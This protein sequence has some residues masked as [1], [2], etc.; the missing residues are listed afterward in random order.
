MHE[1][2]R[3]HEMDTTC[4]F[5]ANQDLYGIGVRAG[6]Y[7]QWTATLLAGLTLPDEA[8]SM[9]SNTLCFQIASLIAVI[10]LTIKGLI[11]Q[12]EVV[13]VL[14]LCFGG[15]LAAN[16]TTNSFQVSVLRS[17]IITQ[18]LGAFVAYSCWFWWEGV[19]IL[20]RPSCKYYTLIFVKVSIDRLRIFGISISTFGCFVFFIMELLI[21]VRMSST[22]R[23]I[24]ILEALKYLRGT[25]GSHGQV[26]ARW[27][28]WT[29]TTLAGL[30]MIYTVIMIEVTIYW[31][32][33]TEANDI[34]SV[35]Q[36]IPLIIGST[37]LFKIY[38]LLALRK[39]CVEDI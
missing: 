8:K 35:G 39:L 9:Q 6:L 30:S 11:S 17:F 28:V 15:F 12:P 34:S 32:E 20:V 7:C 33:I 31:N 19:S 21:L 37:G 36:L 27:K 16:A 14:P 29:S 10:T 18:T 13:V 24:G 2:Q 38:Y 3:S 4:S 22:I 23:S 1:R 26:Q 5:T 25:L